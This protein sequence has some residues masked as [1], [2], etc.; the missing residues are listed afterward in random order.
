MLGGLSCSDKAFPLCREH[1]KEIC[2]FLYR[3]NDPKDLV[4]LLQ[5]LMQ[6]QA[7]GRANE[8]AKS[9]WETFFFD[10]STMAVTTDWCQLKTGHE[11]LMSFFNDKDNFEMDPLLALAFYIVR[12]D[13]CV[14]SGSNGFIFRKEGTDVSAFLKQH[15]ASINCLKTIKQV[16]HNN[17]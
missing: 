1:V 7:I 3:R 10:Q 14:Q 15:K 16:R 6:R 4:I 12:S 17:Q 11:D 2:K 5:L 13:K 8:A 9:R